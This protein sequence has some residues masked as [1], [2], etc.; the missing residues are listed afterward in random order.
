[1]FGRIKYTLGRVNKIG[2]RR[3]A[4]TRLAI[5]ACMQTLANHELQ[6]RQNKN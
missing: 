6:I 2:K 3:L 1:M 5:D 4:A